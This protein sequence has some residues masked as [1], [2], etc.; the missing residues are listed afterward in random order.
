MTTDYD[1]IFSKIKTLNIK[2][3]NDKDDSF[4]ID[5]IYNMLKYFLPAKIAEIFL[6]EIKTFK[7]SKYHEENLDTHLIACS[8]ICYEYSKIFYNKYL[9]DLENIIDYEYFLNMC[10][11]TGLFHDIGKPFAKICGK[12]HNIYVGHSQL[13][14]R[15]F[16]EIFEN[17]KCTQEM[18]WA[19]NHHMCP[20]THQNKI[21]KCS[22]H[23]FPLITSDITGNRTLSYALLAVLEVGDML[24]R[25]DSSYDYDEDAIYNHSFELYD[26]LMAYDHT[27]NTLNIMKLYNLTTIDTVIIHMI[28]ISG[29]GKSYFSNIIYNNKD[30]ESYNITIL[31]RDKALYDTYHAL[32]DK[33]NTLDT[34]TYK[35][36]Y[37]KV[38]EYN[39]DLVEGKKLVQKKWT[40]MIDST[41]LETNNKKRI[42]ILDTCQILYDC[43]WKK[44]IADLSEDSKYIYNNSLKT[45]FYTIPYHMFNSTITSKTDSFNYLPLNSSSTTFNAGM[46]PQL[47]T[48]NSVFDSTKYSYG[49]GSI[50]Q[51]VK[52]TSTILE[53]QKI[54]IDSDIKQVTLI[55]IIKTLQTNYPTDT[56]L[57]ICD[58]LIANLCGLEYDIDNVDNLEKI[59][60]FIN[61]R[62]EHET[63]DNKLIIFTYVDGLQQ[64][65]GTSRDYRG[66]GILYNVT[67][68]T[69]YLVRPSL[70]VFCE[71]SSI[72]KDHKALPYII[73]SWDEFIAPNSSYYD[74]K[75]TINPKKPTKMI[76]TPKFDGSLFNLTF[77]PISHT[78]YPYIND[79]ITNLSGKEAANTNLPINS[80]Y[81]RI[82]GIY[83]IGSKG[84]M[85]SKDPVNTRIH[86]AIVGSYL[87]IECFLDK[88]FLI[89]S[90]YHT[91][92]TMHFEAIDAI[93]SAELTVYYGKAWLPYFGI[94]TYNQENDEKI[95]N[96]PNTNDMTVTCEM[97]SFESLSELQQFYNN[98]YD[99]LLDGDQEIEPEGYVLHIFDEDEWIPIKYKYKIFHTAHKPDSK[100]HLDLA[101]KLV[102]DPKYKLICNRL[103]KFREKPSVETIINQVDFINKLQTIINKYNIITNKKDWAIFWKN[104]NNIEPIESLFITLKDALCVHYPQYQPKFEKCAFN[105]IMRLFQKSNY[106]SE[107]N[108]MI[109]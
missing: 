20:C 28:G 91:I 98:N 65:N 21:D 81:S 18:T 47:A 80:Y 109:N 82:E 108:N 71:M 44:T 103:A 96:L 3:N 52:F 27:M 12:N 90:K 86:N 35:Q 32:F 37:D 87:T 40:E 51:L 66:E 38:H 75:Y 102:S 72:V 83:I 48:E 42:I 84:T 5:E 67:T 56:Y 63:L 61:Y 97:K 93:P 36:I 60:K 79:L 13:G 100:H 43:S 50:D 25:L 4:S 23:V 33:E 17:K 45:C 41:L 106:I 31:E 59:N 78:L 1:K 29:S 14:T 64:F 101:R 88:T 99:K 94:T 105:F 53:K 85:F 16:S 49:T 39:K 70:P 22:K 30:L 24:G 62:I 15:V 26:K 68:N 69:F 92:S 107:L 58:K 95:F 54:N 11:I 19:I 74:L 77:I 9:N 73:D 10:L 104:S 7:E 89:F 2:I 57:Q 34:L 8:L 76:L 46:W 6:N 55:N